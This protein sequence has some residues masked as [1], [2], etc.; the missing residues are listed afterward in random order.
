MVF[1]VQGGLKPGFYSSSCPNAESI[2]KSTVQAE[3]NKDPTIAAGLL[4]LHFHDCFVQGCDG[5]VLISG[6]SAERNAVTNTGL[7]GFEVIGNAK[8][9]LEDS[10][11]GVVSCADILALAAR[12][13]VDLSGG[14]SWGVP[15]GRRDGRNSSSSEALNLPSPF[16]TIEVQRSKF[17]AKGLD[18]HDLVTLVGAHTI[19]Q[20]DCRFF[21]YR[22]YNFTRTGNADPSID[23]QFLAEL[24]TACPKNGDGLKKVALDKDSQMKF[25]VSFFKNVRNG[26]GILESDQRLLGDPSTKDIV[27]KYAG[28]LRGL[29]GLRFNF[30]FQKAMIKMS[31]IEVKSG[32]Q[33]EI[34]KVC[35]KF[36]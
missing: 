29:L 30:N 32:T 19:G 10:C 28:T 4:R 11:P 9:Q 16:D 5:S 12:D 8:T 26:N 34:R 14:P 27:E 22:L 36:N 17:A 20:T 15:T 18:D 21:S 6:T 1:H 25:D 13:A 24:Q 2:V 35:S 33:G 3:F 7:R 31:S 23:Q